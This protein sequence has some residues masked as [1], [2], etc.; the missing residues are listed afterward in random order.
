MR[1]RRINVYGGGNVW[2]GC[3]TYFLMLKTDRFN[4]LWYYVFSLFV[5]KIVV[6]LW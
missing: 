6:S 5:S 4:V 2:D 3:V 1:D